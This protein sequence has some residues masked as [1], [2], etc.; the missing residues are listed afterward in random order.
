[1][2][3]VSSRQNDAVRSFRALANEPDSSGTRLLLDGAHLVHEALQAGVRFEIAAVASSRL[4][5]DTEERRLATTLEHR[6]V[7]VVVAADQVF[8]AMSPVRTPSGIVAIATR[9]PSST[10]RICH[11][12]GGFTLATV[13][14]Q[15]PGNLGALIRVAEAGGV[16]GML[17]CA[18]GRFGRGASVLVEGVAR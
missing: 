2:R 14:V 9:E 8:D 5:A 3:R 16:T 17:V 7:D 1:M 15:D 18:G 10:S 12:A 4:D 6:G 13:G 11:D